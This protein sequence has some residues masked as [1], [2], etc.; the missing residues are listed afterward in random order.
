MEG[1]II[2]F[3]VCLFCRVNLTRE[4]PGALIEIAVPPYQRMIYNNKIIGLEATKSGFYVNKK[5]LCY[6]VYHS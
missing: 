3:I 2:P 6:L 1:E 5:K 4:N